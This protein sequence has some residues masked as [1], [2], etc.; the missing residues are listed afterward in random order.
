M[1]SKNAIFFDKSESNSRLTVPRLM[2][3][4]PPLTQ[5]AFQTFQFDWFNGS[6]IV[7]VIIYALGLVFL[8]AITEI[9]GGSSNLCD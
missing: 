8:A 1:H 6:L 5:V 3:L 2:Q 7:F 4:F 9:R